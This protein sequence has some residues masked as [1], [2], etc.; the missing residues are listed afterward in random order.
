MK[1]A[2]RPVDP[3]RRMQRHPRGAL[4]PAHGRTHVLH[5]SSSVLT[6]WVA[7]RSMHTPASG[8]G[9]AKHHTRFFATQPRLF[10]QETFRSKKAVKNKYK[11]RTFLSQA[12]PGIAGCSPVVGESETGKSRAWTYTR[13][14]DRSDFDPQLLCKLSLGKFP[15]EMHRRRLPFVRFCKI[16]YE[17]CTSGRYRAGCKFWS[18]F[19]CSAPSCLSMIYLLCLCMCGRSRC[20]CG[21]I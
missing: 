4:Q 2:R 13:S 1:S 10:F 12:Q 16:A 3:E 17:H 9:S 6:T 14:R 20:G 19:L 5:D 8:A 11:S 15:T 7:V 21:M 18:P